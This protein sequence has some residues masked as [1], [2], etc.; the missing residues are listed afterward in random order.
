MWLSK[1]DGSCGSSKDSLFGDLFQEVKSAA[2]SAQLSYPL[3]C[4]LEKCDRATRE[5]ICSMSRDGCSPLFV[6]CKRG[7]VEVR[8]RV[9]NLFNDRASLVLDL[10][11]IPSNASRCEIEAMKTI[12]T[13]DPAMNAEICL[14]FACLAAGRV[15]R[16]GPSFLCAASERQIL[17]SSL[18][19][20]RQ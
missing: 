3:R 10:E 1:V 8:T 11:G 16:M 17:H 2:P 12:P 9:L 4:R 18:A 7:N 13:L 6:A 5:A 15:G 20:R 19:Y 14:L